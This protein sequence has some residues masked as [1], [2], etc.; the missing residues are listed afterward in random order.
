MKKILYKIIKN[1]NKKLINYIFFIFIHK[2][3]IGILDTGM[4]IY[5]RQNVVFI[6]ISYK[7]ITI[8]NN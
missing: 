2:V 1:I 6:F 5:S 4:G 8:N 7:N 3:D